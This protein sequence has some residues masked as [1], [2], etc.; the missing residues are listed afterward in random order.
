MR[1]LFAALLSC[2][3]FYISAAAAFGQPTSLQ[4]Y[5]DGLRLLDQLDL[6][7]AAD[8]FRAALAG[9]LEPAWTV[10]WSHVR[11]A[12]VFSLNGQYERAL[13]EAT[14]VRDSSDDTKGAR[15]KAAE[16]ISS[17]RIPSQPSH[18]VDHAIPSTRAGPEYS[19]EGR[20]A[21]L[22]GEA[23][24]SAV[25]GEDGAAR[26]IRIL[27][28]LGLGL[29]EKAIEAAARWRFDPVFAGPATL[30]VDFLLPERLSRWH[31]TR[32]EFRPPEGASRPVF[33]DA[34][35]PMGA[36]VSRRNMDEASVI[37]AIG[38]AGTA[39][40][41]FEIDER[42]FPV[43]FHVLHASDEIWG[44]EAIAVVSDWRF[45]PGMKGGVP[46]SVPA[47]VT[48]MWGSRNMSLVT[49]AASHFPVELDPPV[50]IDASAKVLQSFPR[51]T[52]SRL[53]MRSSKARSDWNWWCEETGRLRMC[54]WS[55]RWAWVSM[56][57]RWNRFP[58]GAS[59]PE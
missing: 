24:L 35:Y 50:P 36:G 54:A 38:R 39:M 34:P 7:P 26:D 30:K 6:Q 58:N 52:P 56:K 46:V 10:V 55:S 4:H 41:R 23:M 44:G 12:E 2:A 1:S 43:H 22:E 18:S 25:I 51:P 11:L 40:L 31:L 5:Q 14:E 20:I 33:L 37:A 15:E 57:A 47:L 53:A 9:D 32:A 27:R 8:E 42:G 21:G 48:V 16:L 49:M 28:P 3:S 29:D 13:A 17:L 59:A 19:A 45:K